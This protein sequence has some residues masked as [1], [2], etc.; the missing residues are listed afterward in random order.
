MARW[1]WRCGSSSKKRQPECQ[2]VFLL[3]D[4]LVLTCFVTPDELGPDLLEG[5]LR[6]IESQVE[7]VVDNWKPKQVA[8][9]LQGEQRQITFPKQGVHHLNAEPGI[10]EE[11]PIPI[12]QNVSKQNPPNVTVFTS[13]SPSSDCLGRQR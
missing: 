8:I 2:L 10:V 3:L 5:I 4:H 7:I 6:R 12:P 13:Q 1:R 9:A 11:R